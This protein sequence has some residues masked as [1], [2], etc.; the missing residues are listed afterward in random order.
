[1][2]AEHYAAVID[3]LPGGAAAFPSSTEYPSQTLYPA[4]GTTLQIY[5]GDVPDEP[6]YPYVV[7]WGDTGTEDSEALSDDPTT[8]TLKVYATCA[9]L[10]FDSAAIAVQM[11][12]SAL[13]RAQPVVAGRVTYRMVQ[14]P[15]QP[16]QAD[17]S[18]SIPGI[19]HPF[20]A[21][22]QFTLI[23]DPA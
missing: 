1:M 20:Y 4:G 18:I 5:K 19:G 2:I 22:D 23:S 3:L 12:R 15:Q 17:K 13:N 9:G 8:L 6:V 7:I 21:V 14:T 16:I 10:T 11:V